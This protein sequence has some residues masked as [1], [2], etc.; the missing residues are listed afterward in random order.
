MDTDVRGYF[1]RGLRE[2]ERG[3]VLQIEGQQWVA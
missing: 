1:R 3:Q 2:R